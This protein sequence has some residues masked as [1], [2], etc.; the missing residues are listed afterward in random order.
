[1]NLLIT[2]FTLQMEVHPEQPLSR[3]QV[4]Q[5]LYKYETAQGE[6]NVHEMF[7][8]LHPVYKRLHKLT[9]KHADSLEWLLKHV[10]K[11]EKLYGKR[12]K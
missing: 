1:M 8:K 4:R 2:D 12:K 5:M 9:Q 3:K 6:N 10:A 7:R 11:V